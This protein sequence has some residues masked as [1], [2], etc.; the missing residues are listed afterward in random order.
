[1]A[2][3]VRRMRHLA[4]GKCRL[5]HFDEL[6]GGQRSGQYLPPN[7]AIGVVLHG[8]LIVVEDDRLRQLAIRT[9][10]GASLCFSHYTAQSRKGR[11]PYTE[12]TSV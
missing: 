8:K 1:M 12:I 4:G 11:E 3:T 9:G 2:V 10:R 5:V 7:T 6:A